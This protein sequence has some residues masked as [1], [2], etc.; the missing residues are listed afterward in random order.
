MK[1]TE[2]IDYI[3][4]HSFADPDGKLMFELLLRV[5]RLE[6]RIGVMKGDN[7]VPAQITASKLEGKLFKERLARF[8]AEYLTKDSDK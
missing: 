8:E 1:E 2:L 6:A 5:L 4:N 7:Y 3:I